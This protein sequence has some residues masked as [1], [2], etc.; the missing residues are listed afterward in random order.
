MFQSTTTERNPMAE[1]VTTVERIGTMR[2]ARI[3]KINTVTQN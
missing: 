3:Q 1:M 2:E